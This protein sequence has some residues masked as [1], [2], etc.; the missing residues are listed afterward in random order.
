MQKKLERTNNK[1]KGQVKK[2]KDRKRWER[3]V[4]KRKI[5]ERN[6][7]N[8]FLFQRKEMLYRDGR[9]S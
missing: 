4:D 7:I 3:I 8:I 2:I 6:V 9:V 5:L 1:K